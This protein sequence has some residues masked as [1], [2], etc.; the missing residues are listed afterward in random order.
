[1]AIKKILVAVDGSEGSD[2]ALEMAKE[3]ALPN[4][5]TQVDLVY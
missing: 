3:V 1:M 5:E 2:R 4:P